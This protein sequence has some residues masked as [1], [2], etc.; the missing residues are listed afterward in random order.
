MA[1]SNPAWLW[2]W[3]S[4]ISPENWQEKVFTLEGVYKDWKSCFTPS[5]AQTQTQDY[6]G[7]EETGKYDITKG[8]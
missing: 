1:C 5:N 6:M 7:H 4:I 2:S 8:N 3:D